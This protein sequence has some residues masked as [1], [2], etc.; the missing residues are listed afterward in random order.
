MTKTL[1]RVLVAALF[2]GLAAA[3][4]GAAGAKILDGTD[5]RGDVRSFDARTETLKPEPTVTNGDVIRTRFRHAKHRIYV[6][7][8]FADLRRQGEFRG[9]FLQIR[10]NEGVRRDVQFVAGKG[11]W[12]GETEMTR[13]DGRH[14]RCHVLHTI[15][16]DANVVTLNF[17]RGCISNPRWV[18][19]GLGS[20]WFESASNQDVKAYVDDS[21]RDGF[22]GDDLRY[23]RRI[24]HM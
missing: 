9:D 3:P 14:V 21:Q 16:Y 17:L 19:I 13:P 12:R 4:A 6:R 2:T 10:T 15:D 8:A 23:S 22:V 1:R 11:D 18:Q 20:V 7:V 5:A 24:G